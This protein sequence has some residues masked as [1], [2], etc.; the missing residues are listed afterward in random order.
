MNGKVAFDEEGLLE[1]IITHR[2]VSSVVV[3]TAFYVNK[4]LIVAHG[5]N[6]MHT[7]YSILK[8]GYLTKVWN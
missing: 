1:S 6:D 4:M 2:E 8:T 5:Y 3:K 7:S